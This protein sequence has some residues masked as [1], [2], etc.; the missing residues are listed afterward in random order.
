MS[1]G[2][3][4]AGDRDMRPRIV[5]A[6]TTFQAELG[7][8]LRMTRAMAH[9]TR[10]NVSERMVSRPS[11]GTISAWE[12]GT[13]QI[14]IDRLMDFCHVVGR[15]VES[16]WPVDGRRTQVIRAP[17]LRQLDDP[18]LKPLAAWAKTYGNELIRL[19]PDAI[20]AAAALCKVPPD[21]LR[22]RLLRLQRF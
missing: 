2:N 18:P 1:T 4:G 17:R 8:N 10:E 13:R 7:R 12:A 22:Q 20:E 15:P 3:S 21:W 16:V 9:L 11:V 14:P 6:Q 5:T 19:T